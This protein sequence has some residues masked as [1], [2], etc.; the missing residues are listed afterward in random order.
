V[1]INSRAG[2]EVRVTIE[3]LARRVTEAESVGN[4]DQCIEAVPASNRLA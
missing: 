1:S 4:L 3:V 2:R